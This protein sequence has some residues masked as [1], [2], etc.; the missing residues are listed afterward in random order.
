MLYSGS[1]HVTSGI[2]V[3]KKG[4]V[5]LKLGRQ[6][7]TEVEGEAEELW[8][9]SLSRRPTSDVTPTARDL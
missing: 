3:V 1:S 7:E 8:K 2:A 9:T 6:K 4:A 5:S